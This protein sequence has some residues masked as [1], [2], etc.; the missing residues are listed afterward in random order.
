MKSN[1]NHWYITATILPNE[2]ENYSLKITVTSPSELM[3]NQIGKYLTGIFQMASVH[4]KQLEKSDYRAVSYPPTPHLV[5]G[6]FY[7]KICLFHFFSHH[8]I[9]M[10]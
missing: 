2:F 6:Y 8:K 1:Q 9:E 3:T 4:G 5:T 7:A 10:N